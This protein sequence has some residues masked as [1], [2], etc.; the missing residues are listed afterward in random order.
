[1]DRKW[2]LYIFIKYAISAI[3]YFVGSTQKSSHQ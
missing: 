2:V 1:M 3:G